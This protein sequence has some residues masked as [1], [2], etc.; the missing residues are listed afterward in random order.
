[1]GIFFKKTMLVLLFQDRPPLFVSTVAFA[2]ILI[3]LVQPALGASRAKLLRPFGLRLVNHVTS[4]KP[5]A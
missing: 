4:L 1:M 2:N 5:M 3:V